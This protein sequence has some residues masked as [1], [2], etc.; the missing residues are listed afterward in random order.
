MA[1]HQIII[2]HKLDPAELRQR[3]D[4]AAVKLA[5]EYGLQCSWS[6]ETV[7]QVTRKGLNASVHLELDQV[8]VELELGF[9]MSAASGSIRTGITKQLA[10]LLVG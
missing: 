3:M 2:P 6:A 9:L 4:R 1:R 8:R 5:S 7:M 10:D